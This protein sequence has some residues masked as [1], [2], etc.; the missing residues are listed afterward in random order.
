MKVQAV[1]ANGIVV[2]LLVRYS[3]QTGRL[4]TTQ[5]VLDVAG[6]RADELTAASAQFDIYKKDWCICGSCEDD[7]YYKSDNL[8]A[9]V[10][11]VALCWNYK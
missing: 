11:Y 7:D 1:K 8:V 3:P 2:E 9:T 4:Y 5:M 10:P 6:V